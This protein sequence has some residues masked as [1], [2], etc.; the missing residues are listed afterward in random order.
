MLK[1]IKEIFYNEYIYI[2]T[3][4]PHMNFT[5]I[6][7]HSLTVLNLRIPIKCIYNDYYIILYFTCNDPFGVFINGFSNI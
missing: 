7:L 4:Q 6:S 2:Y 5:V 3:P 1:I